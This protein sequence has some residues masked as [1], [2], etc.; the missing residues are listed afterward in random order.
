MLTSEALAAT[1]EPS[2]QS[3]GDELL[4]FSERI[5]V[6]CGLLWECMSVG[7]LLGAFGGGQTQGGSEAGA[8]HTMRRLKWGRR[9]T[10]YFYIFHTL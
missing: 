7:V 2:A 1:G 5:V 10:F 8:L 3:V 6:G 4:V 9:F